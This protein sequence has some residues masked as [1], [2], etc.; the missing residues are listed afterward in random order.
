MLLLVGLRGRLVGECTEALGALPLLANTASKFPVLIEK[1][2]LSIRACRRR[3]SAHT[4]TVGERSDEAPSRLKDA[5]RVGP[6]P[7]AAAKPT[8]NRAMMRQ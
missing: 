7:A 3:L 6:R 8:S 4:A 2:R 5:P 1:H